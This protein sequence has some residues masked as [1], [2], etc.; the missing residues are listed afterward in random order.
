MASWEGGSKMR[1]AAKRPKPG[2]VHG[3][4]RNPIPYRVA[5]GGSSRAPRPN[6]GGEAS[7]GFETQRGDRGYTELPLQCLAQSFDFLGG[8]RMGRSR[9]L[10]HDDLALKSGIGNK[11]LIALAWDNLSQ[12]GP[13]NRFFRTCQDHRVRVGHVAVPPDRQ[14]AMD[15]SATQFRAPSTSWM[16][17]RM[18]RAASRALR[19]TKSIPAGAPFTW[20]NGW[21]SS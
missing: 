18:Y 3:R 17:R 21:Q 8:Q 11:G 15:S 1:A 9:A 5:G 16:R 7:E 6:S 13:P 2:H 12:L 20:G 10:G 14:P 4:V 19:S